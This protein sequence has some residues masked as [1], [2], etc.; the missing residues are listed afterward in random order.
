MENP[1]TNVDF[2]FFFFFV[3][4]VSLI[5]LPKNDR[6]DLKMGCTDA[7]RRQLQSML[8]IG[9]STYFFDEIMAVLV[10]P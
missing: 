2:A 6:H 5:T 8:K 4:L 10:L 1:G 7:L 9:V 3:N